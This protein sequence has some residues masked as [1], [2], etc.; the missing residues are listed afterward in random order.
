MARCSILYWQ[1]IPSMVEARDAEGSHK[2]ELSARFQGLIDLIAMRRGLTGT[3]EY[4][5]AWR[6]ERLSERDGSAR[7]AAE[8]IA[9]ELEER[10]EAI[11]ADALAAL[12]D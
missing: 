12:Q 3:E 11:R 7:G 5:S 10:Y 4:L 8:A 1:D 9:A 2:I 6:R